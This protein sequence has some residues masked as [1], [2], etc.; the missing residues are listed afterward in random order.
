MPK[1]KQRSMA[2]SNDGV[3]GGCVVSLWQMPY[4]LHGRPDAAE[5]QHI[6]LGLSFLKYIS[7]AC[8]ATDGGVCECFGGNK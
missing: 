4:A 1:T 2:S 5:Y 3:T 6:V 8:K 7:D